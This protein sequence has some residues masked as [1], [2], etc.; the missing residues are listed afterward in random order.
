MYS[1]FNLMERK[2]EMKKTGTISALIRMRTRM[3]EKGKNTKVLDRRIEKLKG[4]ALQI[5]KSY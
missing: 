5:R 2:E 3:R 4:E 1:N